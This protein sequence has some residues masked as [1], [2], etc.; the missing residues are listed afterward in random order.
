MWVSKTPFGPSAKFHVYNVHTMDELK[1]TGNCMQGS[2]PILSFD[3]SF[4]TQPHLQLIKALFVDAFGTPRGH[5]KSKPFI[6]RI[7]CFYWADEKIWVRN[8]QIVD[9]S[10]MG[11]LETQAQRKGEELTSLVEIGPRFV[12]NPMRIFAGSFGGPTLYQNPAFVSPNAIR[13]EKKR[14]M[15][16][17]LSKRMQGNEERKKKAAALKPYKDELADLFRG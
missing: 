16:Q 11:K 1:L 9:K 17:V 15:G 14:E 7:M 6:D 13:A 3:G 10:D 4:E 2:R 5:P 8:Y 12:L